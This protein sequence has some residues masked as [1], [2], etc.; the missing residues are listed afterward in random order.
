MPDIV[1]I[2]GHRAEAGSEAA[3]QLET[4]VALLNHAAM[5]TA[6]CAQG[7]ALAPRERQ[8]AGAALRRAKSAPGYLGVA[9]AG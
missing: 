5:L 1:T 8:R 3:R 7:R 6:C 2:A 4:R 9:D